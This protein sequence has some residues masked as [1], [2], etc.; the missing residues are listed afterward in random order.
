MVERKKGGGSFDPPPSKDGDFRGGEG[1]GVSEVPVF[2]RGV[3]TWPL[4]VYI[5]TSSNI[6][7][8]L[9]VYLSS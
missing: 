6:K 1:R 4:N 2:Q 5:V 8:K 7:C 3:A 9:F